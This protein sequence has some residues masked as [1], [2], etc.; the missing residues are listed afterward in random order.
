VKKGG[1][2]SLEEIRSKYGSEVVSKRYQES[3]PYLNARSER[4]RNRSKGANL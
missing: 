2:K 3:K 4:R 1:Q